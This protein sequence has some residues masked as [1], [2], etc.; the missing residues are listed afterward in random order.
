V[1]RSR[2]GGEIQ[3]SNIKIGGD[4]KLTSL[5]NGVEKATIKLSEKQLFS[6]RGKNI[7]INCLYGALWVT[8]PKKGERILKSGQTIRVSSKGKVCIVALSNAFF[9][10]SKR[11]WYASTKTNG[12]SGAKYGNTNIFPF[13]C[14]THGFLTEKKRHRRRT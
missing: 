7:Q 6:V 5:F 8:W 11:R 14:E 2:T 9:Q 12:K 4:M 3:V 13:P 10:M 1:A